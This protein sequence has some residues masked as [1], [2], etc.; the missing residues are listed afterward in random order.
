MKLHFV[1]EMAEQLMMD[2]SVLMII[3]EKIT[4][5]MAYDSQVFGKICRRSALSDQMIG[6][7]P[8][9]KKVVVYDMGI[10]K[11]A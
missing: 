3:A 6:L 4:D 8:N 2:F 7:I 11:T 1:E 9:K 5:I 10:L